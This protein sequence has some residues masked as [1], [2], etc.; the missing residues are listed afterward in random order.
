MIPRWFWIQALLWA[1]SPELQMSSLFTY[2]QAILWAVDMA[3]YFKFYV[4]FACPICSW[5][6]P[7]AVINFTTTTTLQGPANYTPQLQGAILTVTDIQ[8]GHQ[9][10][11]QA[12][13]SYLA[14]ELPITVVRTESE[15]PFPKVCQALHSKQK[16]Y[17]R[18]GNP[19]LRPKDHSQAVL[20]FIY[21]K[22]GI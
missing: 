8:E 3:K 22:C 4:S 2:L 10:S 20:R 5:Y 14:H 15:G 19:W 1:S 17:W 7:M 13:H 9:H 6:G 18:W 12:C 16:I 21:L 11:Q